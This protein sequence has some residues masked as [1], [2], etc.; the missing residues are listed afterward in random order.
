M[1][2]L[3]TPLKYRTF[4]ATGDVLIRAELDLQ[5]K[6]NKQTWADLPFLV[7]SG[8]E[9][10]TMAAFVAK[11]MDLP[12]PQQATRGAVHRQTGLPIRAGYLR[13]RVVGM[14]ATEYVFPCFFLGDPD[15]LPDPLAPPATMPRR[16]LGLSGVIDKLDIRCDGTPVPAL[17][18]PYGTLIVEKR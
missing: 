1:S 18:A 14:D 15:V 2:R 13:V 16:L 9:M 4:W 6:T 17:R 10:T 12:M 11:R 8:T 7:D 5:L 3:V